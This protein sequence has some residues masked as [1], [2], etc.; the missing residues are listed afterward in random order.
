M[1][2]E[3]DDISEFEIISAKEDQ[4]G[5]RMKSTFDN[6]KLQKIQNLNFD[7]KAP[8]EGLLSYLNKRY[9]HKK[10]T[11]HEYQKIE[12]SITINKAKGNIK[13]NLLTKETINETLSKIKNDKIRDKIKYVYLAGVQIII[14]SLFP[15]NL[16]TPIVLSLHDK[17]LIQTHESHLGSIQ[18]NL[19]YTKLMFTCYPKYSIHLGDKD[20][21]NSLSLYFK[22]LRNDFM[23]EGNNVMTMYYSA[24]YTLSNSN[25]G[26]IYQDKPFIEISD[27]C[28]E[29][30]EIIE[31]QKLDR[32]EIPANYILSLEDNIPEENNIQ[33]IDLPRFRGNSLIGNSSRNSTSRRSF[34]RIR[35]EVHSP[36]L[37]IGNYYNGER[38]VEETKILIDTGASCNHIQAD[39]CEMIGT[40]TSPYVYKNYDGQT[41]E[42]NLKVEIPIRLQGITFLVDCYKDNRMQGNGHYD[43]LLGN[44][45][46]DRLDNYKITKEGIEIHNE[47]IC[48]FIERQ[49]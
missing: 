5:Y 4:E 44:S 40:L 28:R 16:N 35:E 29:I 14:K 46:L 43:I 27:E 34:L 41:L 30:A 2:E 11:I 18:G 7:L 48:I 20:F 45:F 10:Y 13:L 42:C 33:R 22:F 36:F 3:E 49:K 38:E 12:R 6:R 37:I 8:G 39:K 9:M 19:A 21:D 47:D 32:I 15:E 25:Y 23:K 1:I 26:R 24:L 17:R 31:P